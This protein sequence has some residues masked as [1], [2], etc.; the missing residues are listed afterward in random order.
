MIRT[1]RSLMAA[2]VFVI[3][4][5]CALCASA[6]P[7]LPQ[8]TPVPGGVA[9]LPL[10][11]ISSTAVKPQVRYKER[12]VMVLAHQGQWLAIVGLSLKA[13]VGLH[14]LDITL[15]PPVE[16]D[17][18]TSVSP[19]T[20]YR[21]NFDVMDKAYKTQR[22]TIKNKRKVNPNPDDQARIE[23]D[24][25]KIVKAKQHWSD[26]P[27][28]SLLLQWPLRGR[29]SSVFGLRRIFNNQPRNPHSGLD[30]AAPQGTPIIAPA[31]GVVIDT[32]DY[33]FNGQTVFVDHG[34]GMVTMYC[35]LSKISRTVGEEIVT[36]DE[37]GLVGAT[38]RVTGPHLH[39]GVLLNGELV[40]PNLFLAPL[41]S[42]NQT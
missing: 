12:D 27:A 35:H 20:T 36:G 17:A 6:E 3:S 10:A 18:A 37:L 25:F 16:R 24:Y 22:L 33:F 28:K 21:L 39:F 11:D 14:Q 38:G 13:E 26:Q 41:A 19:A 15:T 9:V 32:G 42:D 1:Y 8:H 29:I 4:L 30:I 31:D 40:D 5:S 34:Q 23:Q 2:L 7:W